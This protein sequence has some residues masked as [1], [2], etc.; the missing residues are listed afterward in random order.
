MGINA[1]THNWTV[2]KGQEPLDHSVL[3]SMSSTPSDRGSG[4]YVEQEVEWR[5]LPSRHETD[6]HRTSRSL[7]QYAQELHTGSSQ[8]GSH[9]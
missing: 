7:W 4:I 2:S 8:T 6:A 3:P 1:E 9:P 5:Q